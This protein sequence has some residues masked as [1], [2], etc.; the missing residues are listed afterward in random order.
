MQD[1]L[2]PSFFV[3]NTGSNTRLRWWSPR[4]W[5]SRDKPIPRLLVLLESW[6]VRVPPILSVKGTRHTILNPINHVRAD[7]PQQR[8]EKMGLCR[9]TMHEIMVLIGFYDCF[10]DFL[11]LYHFHRLPLLPF[12]HISAHSL[13]DSSSRSPVLHEGWRHSRYQNQ[14]IV[15]I[16]SIHYSSALSISTTRISTLTKGLTNKRPR[17]MFWFPDKRLLDKMNRP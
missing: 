16:L 3:L 14:I 4:R 6:Q 10:W 9:N 1:Y 8:A 11:I 5:C 12:S 2:S 7:S 13:A 15:L 17:H